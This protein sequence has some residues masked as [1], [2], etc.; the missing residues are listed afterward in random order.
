MINEHPH[1]ESIFRGK[2]IVIADDDP[3]HDAFRDLCDGFLAAGR[4]A[5]RT[6]PP[7]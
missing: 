2:T 5:G 1:M 6:T 4:L 7:T 3:N